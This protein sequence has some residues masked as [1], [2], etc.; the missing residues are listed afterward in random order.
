[1][2]GAVQIVGCVV[3]ASI[4]LA[5]GGAGFSANAADAQC[6]KED[7]EAVVEV[8]ASSLRDLNS[9][10]RPEFQEKLRELKAKRKW[11]QDEF[12]EKAAPFVRDDKTAVYDKSTD[13]LLS[14]ISSMGQAGAQSPKPDCA[15]L[16]ELRA[17]MKVLVDT[18]TAKWSYMFEK[19]DAE[20]AK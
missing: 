12:I 2:G 13:E 11:T 4:A 8:T 16:L 14:A 7:F 6:K 19:L 20:L 3:L 17:R 5:V 15:M 10:N 1:M 9:K 18:Q